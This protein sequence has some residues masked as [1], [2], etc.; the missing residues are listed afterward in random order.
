MAHLAFVC[1]GL[2]SNSASRDLGLDGPGYGHFHI[3][4]H[5]GV[6]LWLAASVA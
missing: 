2:G 4:E 1:I 3:N 5:G 6:A